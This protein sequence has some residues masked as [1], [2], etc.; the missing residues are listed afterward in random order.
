MNELPATPKEMKQ[1]IRS[2]IRSHRF[3][4][5]KVTLV[6]CLMTAAAG[7]NNYVAAHYK[8]HHM[9]WLHCFWG[10]GA[11]LGPVIMAGFISGGGHWRSGYLTVSLR[12]P[13]IPGRKS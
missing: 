8:A 10:V 11:T 9:S 13:A 3:G 5:G 2:G 7:L 1:V 12:P 4:T 6:S